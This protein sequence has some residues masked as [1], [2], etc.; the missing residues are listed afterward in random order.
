MVPSE[1]AIDYRNVK[2]IVTIE[3][4]PSSGKI[5][6]NLAAAIRQAGD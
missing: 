1:H 5:T 4:S 3:Y 2:S 6:Y